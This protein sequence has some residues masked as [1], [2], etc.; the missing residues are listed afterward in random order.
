[1]SAEVVRRRTLSLEEEGILLEECDPLIRTLVVFA[2]GTGMRQGEILSLSA[3]DIDL[4]H[5]QINIRA[6]NTKTLTSRAVPISKRVEAELEGLPKSGKLFESEWFPKKDWRAAL[7]SAGIEDFHF[8]DLRMTFGQRLI[9]RGLGISEVGKL[10]GHANVSTT[11][12]HYQTSSDVTTQ[13]AKA[14]LDGH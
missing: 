9:D 5:Q 7:S 1:M 12:R 10:L 8:H 2:L 11:Y 14:L 3:E 4:K 13:K 6:L